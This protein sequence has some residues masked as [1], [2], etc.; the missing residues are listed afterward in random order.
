M[1]EGRATPKSTRRQLVQGISAAAGLVAMPHIVRAQT[2]IVMKIGTPT[3]NDTQHEWMRIFARIV[4]TKSKGAIKGELYPASQLGSAPR[5]IEGA[6]FGTVQVVA[7]PPEFLSGVD[8]RYEVLGAPALFKNFGHAQ[9][10]L[11]QPD[12]NRAFLSIGDSKGLVGIGLYVAAQMIINSRMRLETPEDVRGKKIRVL[13]SAMQTE[14]VKRL[15]G[16]GIPMPLSEVLPALQQGTIDGM[17]G[18]IPTLTPFRVYDA[19]KFILDTEH[20]TVC[21][22]SLAS[23]I[24]LDKLPKELRTIVLDAGQQASREVYA[25]AVD[26]IEQQ[27]KIWVDNGGEIVKLAPDVHEGLVKLMRPI[28]ADIAGRRPAELELFKLLVQTTETTA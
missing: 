6:Q 1:L 11:L 12:F 21:A 5:M 20:A 9:R 24:W 2:P 28:G 8:A 27:R 3:L 14:Q 18:S 10:C 22:V 13:A 17:M 23:K 16:T 4:E 7:L 25:W 19:S 15:G 26:F